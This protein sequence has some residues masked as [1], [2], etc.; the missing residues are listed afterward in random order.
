MVCDVQ[1]LLDTNPCYSALSP[2][3]AEVVETQMLCSLFNHL[4]SGAE[5]TCDIQALLDEAECLYNL[6][7]D[8]LRVIR[9]QLLCNIGGLV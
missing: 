2:H 9:L 8:Q 3:M 6:S 4:D 5:F 1:A 7:S